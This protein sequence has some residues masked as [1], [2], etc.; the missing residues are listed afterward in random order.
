[1]ISRQA[2]SQSQR[3]PHRLHSWLLI[4]QAPGRLEALLPA[5]LPACSLV[6]HKRLSDG[7]VAS[8]APLN[9][10]PFAALTA[11]LRLLRLRGL[12]SLAPAVL[13]DP[14]LRR[15]LLVVILAKP[16]EGLVCS[17]LFRA[18]VSALCDLLQLAAR[19]ELQQTGCDLQLF[20][21]LAVC[22]LQHL[23]PS[24]AGAARTIL[25]KVVFGPQF[26]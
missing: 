14:E 20:H 9:A 24:Q 25:A 13:Q 21:R 2:G 16:E 18:E 7:S 19:P 22:L 3:S 10:W 12:A 6:A 17:P 4:D 23:H 11:F 5:S 8:H 1:M 26:T 15:Y